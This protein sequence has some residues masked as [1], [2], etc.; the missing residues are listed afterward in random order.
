VAKRK[1]GAALPAHTDDP[2]ALC[3]YCLL[4][5]THPGA[6]LPGLP[7]LPPTMAV[8]PLARWVFSTVPPSHFP[9]PPMRAPPAL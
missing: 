2:T 7:L 3:G 9:T 4:A 8:V 6:A 5:L 1:G